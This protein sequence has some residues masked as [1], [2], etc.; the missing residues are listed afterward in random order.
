[1]CLRARP[2]PIALSEKAGHRSGIGDRAGRCRLLPSAGYRQLQQ[3][4][5]GG[6]LLLLDLASHRE[7]WVRD[8]LGHEHLGFTQD[9]LIR[10]LRR[11]GFIRLTSE[12]LPRGPGDP[13]RVLVITATKGK[14]KA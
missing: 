1:M 2:I 6:R 9:D 11:A 8:K 12:D 4:Q 10:R 3:C 7:E 14:A 13:F 5:P